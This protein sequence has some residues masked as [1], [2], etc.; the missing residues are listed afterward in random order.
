VGKTSYTPSDQTSFGVQLDPAA[1]FFI[2]ENVSISG[3][4]LAA[5]AARATITVS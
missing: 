5:D 4:L 3:S 1:H 2:A